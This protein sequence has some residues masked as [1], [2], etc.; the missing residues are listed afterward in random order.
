M[1][2]SICLFSKSKYK[3]QEGTQKGLYYMIHVDK[4]YAT[5]YSN[6]IKFK[7]KLLSSYS[8]LE[9]KISLTARMHTIPDAWG[10]LYKHDII[11]LLSC[12]SIYLF[13]NL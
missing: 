2:T 4:G 11:Y 7:Y 5:V 1:F 9:T 3:D 12:I 6:F 10:D 13:T 8:T